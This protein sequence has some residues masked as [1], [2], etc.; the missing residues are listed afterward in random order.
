MLL[1]ACAHTH[2]FIDTDTHIHTRTHAHT[3]ALFINTYMHQVSVML[4]NCTSRSLLLIDE[5]GKGTQVS[6]Q[7]NIHI[8][9]TRVHKR[10]CTYTR[11]HNMHAHK[12]IRLHMH[13]HIRNNTHNDID[14][15]VCACVCD[16][17]FECV[18]ACVCVWVQVCLYVCVVC[19]HKEATL[20]RTDKPLVASIHL[21]TAQLF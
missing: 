12:N 18:C 15:C 2:A 21:G 5:F 13:A 4:R 19:V 8:Q 6:A 17:G 16:G 3:H 9:N 11:T 20:I 7:T 1:R 10:T 14:L